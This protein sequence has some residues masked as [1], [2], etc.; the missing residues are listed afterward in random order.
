MIKAYDNHSVRASTVLKTSLSDA[1]IGDLDEFFLIVKRRFFLGV[2]GAFLEA[3]LQK[4]TQ[5]LRTQQR[6]AEALGLKDR[7]SISQMVR[8]GSIDG[9]RFTAALYQYP[10]LIDFL[11][12]QE[13]AALFGFARATSFIKSQIYNDLTIEGSLSPQ[14][15][16]YLIGVLAS[17]KWES[18][19]CDP[20][21]YAVRAIATEIVRDRSISDR[22][23]LD[24]NRYRP[25]QYVLMLQEL[26]LSWAD[27]AV[28][29]LWAIPECI[30]ESDG[31]TEAA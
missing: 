4:L 27:S 29:A 10:A 13:R 6:I 21:P 3:I 8:S 18:A 17:S 30:P 24:N 2:H 7:T 12:T 11:P 14:D 15:F 20:N 16:S 28:V 31:G 9:L 19:L 23:A 26:S 1:L 25:E 5:E 22:G